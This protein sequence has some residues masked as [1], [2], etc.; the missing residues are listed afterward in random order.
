MNKKNIIIISF[1]VIIILLVIGLPLYFF[2]Y[3]KSSSNDLSNINVLCNIFKNNE[4]YF[5]ELNLCNETITTINA[6]QKANQYISRLSSINDEIKGLAIN[7]NLYLTSAINNVKYVPTYSLA[8]V[9]S[10]NTDSII[11][12]AYN[13][14]NS[15]NNYII[16]ETTN[17]IITILTD[18][19]NEAITFIKINITNFDTSTLSN[20]L[21]TI[22]TNINAN[23][24]IISS[25]LIS[26]KKL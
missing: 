6:L 16:N 22:L 8:Y 4:I 3:K 9:D 1:I 5:N 11:Q 21:N 20:N 18:L 26:V 13:H 25:A 7:S 24:N 23:K 2:V 17:N 12:T 15:Y 14:I 10:L 19:T